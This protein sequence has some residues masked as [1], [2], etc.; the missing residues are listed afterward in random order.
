LGKSEPGKSEIREWRKM[1]K[2]ER[3]GGF[4]GKKMP[5]KST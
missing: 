2:A 1:E 3:A 5:G 4:A